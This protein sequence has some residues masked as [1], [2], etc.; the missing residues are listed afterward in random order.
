MKLTLRGGTSSREGSAI[1]W[2]H[3]PHDVYV[4]CSLTLPSVMLKTEDSWQVDVLDFI[5]GV[6][7]ALQS[8]QSLY[9]KTC[10]NDDKDFPNDAQSLGYRSIA[11]D[12]LD[13]HIRKPEDI[14]A[15]SKMGD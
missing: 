13:V 6:P 15:L 2:D 4:Y 3:V 1:A 9:K 5:E 8:S 11:N 12:N 7:D 10:H 14:F